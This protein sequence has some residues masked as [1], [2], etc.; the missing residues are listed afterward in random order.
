MSQCSVG[1]LSAVFGCEDTGRAPPAPQR[2]SQSF[3]FR[4]RS[5]PGRCTVWHAIG[6]PLAQLERGQ[7]VLAS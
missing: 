1:C 7:A 6:T 5:C 4:R 3:R 2:G